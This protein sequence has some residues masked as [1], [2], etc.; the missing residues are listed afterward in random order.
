MS[1]AGSVRSSEDESDSNVTNSSLIRCQHPIVQYGQ[2]HGIFDNDADLLATHYCYRVLILLM[3][4]SLH[5]QTPNSAD[6]VN[7]D[8]KTPTAQLSS[9][10]G[11]KAIGRLLA[12]IDESNVRVLFYLGTPDDILSW[13]RSSRT[14]N[15]VECARL[16]ARIDK[17]L[18]D[19]TGD[20]KLDAR[21]LAAL[22]PTLSWWTIAAEREVRQRGLSRLLKRK[23]SLDWRTW[24]S[25]M[26][27]IETQPVT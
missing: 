4:M 24:L 20:E 27:N 25:P 22:P 3:A 16:N 2:P 12:D 21:S 1:S 18:S 11:E 5:Q 15:A 17:L 10:E 6:S 19:F 13:I 9:A 8:D 23:I 7:H 26:K 14:G